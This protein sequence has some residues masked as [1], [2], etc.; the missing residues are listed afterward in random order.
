MSTNKND[1]DYHK[2]SGIY[3]DVNIKET[4]DTRNSHYSPQ[5]VEPNTFEDNEQFYNQQLSIY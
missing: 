2:L 1:N 4:N 3:H 5:K